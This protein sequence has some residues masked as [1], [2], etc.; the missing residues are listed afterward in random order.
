[1]YPDRAALISAMK[2]AVVHVNGSD[3]DVEIRLDGN[4]RLFG[5]ICGRGSLDDCTHALA[6]LAEAMGLALGLDNGGG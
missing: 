4:D 5:E 2:T 6:M 1:M 3:A